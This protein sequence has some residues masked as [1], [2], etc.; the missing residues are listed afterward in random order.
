MK[1]EFKIG[2]QDKEFVLI[3]DN[4]TWSGA[5]KLGG[6][7]YQVEITHKEAVDSTE[8]VNWGKIEKVLKLI[9]EEQ[10][11]LLAKAEKN[12]FYL[13]NE[14]GLYS[15]SELDQIKGFYLEFVEIFNPMSPQVS[16]SLHFEMI[17]DTWVDV[18][19]RWR[20]VFLETSLVGIE[21]IQI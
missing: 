9:S 11:S 10:A 4:K 16:F 20:V 14:L 18:Y 3:N 17:S 15:Q 8:K 2:E 6:K 12:L 13:V 21:R 5:I 7:F 19:S 1:Y